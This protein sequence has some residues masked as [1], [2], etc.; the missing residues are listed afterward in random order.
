MITN[1]D[2]KAKLLRNVMHFIMDHILFQQRMPSNLVNLILDG[3][4]ALALTEEG[5]GKFKKISEENNH[6][7]FDIGGFGPAPKSKLGEEGLSFVLDED[8]KG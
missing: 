8:L 1:D 7:V 6:F 3:L 5:L 2:N 4:N